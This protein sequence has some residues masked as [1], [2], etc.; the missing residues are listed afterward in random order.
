MINLSP[1][2]ALTPA[3]VQQFH[4][5]RADAIRH[6]AEKFQADP[7]GIY[8]RYGE[9]G[10]EACREDLGYH[11]EFL[12]PVLEFG[13]IEPMVDYLRWL[14]NV[15][16][17]R[18]IP[19]EHLLLSL[20]WLGDFLA[21][22]ME[23]ADG[24]TVLATIACVT[25]RFTATEHNELTDHDRMMPLAW[26]ESAAFESA[27]LAGD[28]HR[29]RSLFEGSLDEGHSLVDVELH[30]IQPALYAIGKKW[31]TNQV[32]V[33][34]EHL[35]T[36]I[37]Q[38]LMMQGLVQAPVFASNGK[39]ILLACVESNHHALGLQ[40]VADAFQLAGWEV[41][42]LGPNMPTAA[43]VQQVQSYAPHLIG[44]SVAFPQH[45]KAIKEI[46]PKLDLAMGLERPP[47]LLGGRAI[48]QF[49]RLADQLGANAWSPDAGSAVI[50]GARL[51]VQRGAQ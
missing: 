44:L 40:M 50:Q 22:K 30:L 48:N 17:S 47:V 12:R 25:A 14:A 38:S 11:L 28:R 32:T 15:L 23:H 45:L 35:A 21:T 4:A 7:A 10:R 5:S 36:A 49:N 3:G 26:A 27:L 19:S 9:R 24:Q 41:Q 16:S 34:Q 51:L 33:A 6:V 43:L 37:S 29:A 39:K 2:T 18:G 42:Y 8:A 13:I 20:D 31:Q 1:T 46:V